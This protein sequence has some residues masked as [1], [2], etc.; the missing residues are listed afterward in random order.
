MAKKIYYDGCWYVVSLEV[1]NR[2]E[3]LQRCIIALLATN[4][5]A[6]AEKCENRIYSIM[7]TALK[8]HDAYETTGGAIA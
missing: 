1:A 8:N 5:Y 4:K 7:C 3:Y 6:A 2:I